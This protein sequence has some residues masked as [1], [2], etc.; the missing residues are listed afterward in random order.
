ML[1]HA[2]AS[3]EAARAAGDEQRI[4]T[5]LRQVEEA[6]RLEAAGGADKEP[7]VPE[8]PDVPESQPPA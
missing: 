5:A 3:L 4:A 8:A 2:Q 7:A 1:Q 6:E